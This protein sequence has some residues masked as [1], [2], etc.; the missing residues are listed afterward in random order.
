MDSRLLAKAPS[1]G[2]HL[3][4]PATV[5]AALRLHEGKTLGASNGLIRCAGIETI[6]HREDSNGPNG[7][8]YVYWQAFAGIGEVWLPINRYSESPLRGI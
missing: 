8:H 7:P 3:S 1:Y 6:R 5:D 4:D 2:E